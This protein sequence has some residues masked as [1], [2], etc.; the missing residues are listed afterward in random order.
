MNRLILAYWKNVTDRG[1]TPKPIY[2]I[3]SA[4]G[5]QPIGYC[6]GRSINKKESLRKMTTLSGNYVLVKMTPKT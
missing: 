1:D 5:Q 6:M 4:G 3:I 2:A